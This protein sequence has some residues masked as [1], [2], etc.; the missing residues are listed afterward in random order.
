MSGILLLLMAL[1]VG[2]IP[3]STT[4]TAGSNVVGGNGSIGYANGVIGTLSV[5]AIGP[6]TIRNITDNIVSGIVVACEI[7]IAAASNPGQAYIGNVVFNGNTFNGAAASYSYAGGLATWQWTT[8]V[9][10]GF[11]NA[12]VYPGTVNYL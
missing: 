12:G 11:V 2:Y 1:G 5:T 8:S 7:I 3:L 4:L 9:G 10:W 6:N